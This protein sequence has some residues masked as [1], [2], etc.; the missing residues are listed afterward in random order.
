MAKN[1]CFMWFLA[2]GICGN[3]MNLGASSIKHSTT[4]STQCQIVAS[5]RPSTSATSRYVPQAKKRSAAHNLMM[6]GMAKI[7]SVAVSSLFPMICSN[8]NIC[9]GQNRYM[10]LTYS[11][12]KVSSRLVRSKNNGG[13][14]CHRRWRRRR[15]AGNTMYAI[16][17]RTFH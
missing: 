1:A 6:A 4:V 7:L 3:W 2:A 11:G 15:T 12:L 8:W 10:R 16:F 13:R 17:A 14:C 5:K 9:V